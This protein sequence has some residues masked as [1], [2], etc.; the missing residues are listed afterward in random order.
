[1]R[2]E[3]TVKTK[4][5]RERI[6]DA[7]GEILH[8]EGA[9]KLTQPQVARAAGIRQS[10]LTYY[11]PRRADLLMAL[12]TRFLETASE[13]LGSLSAARGATKPRA[14]LATVHRLVTNPRQ[15]RSFLGLIVEADQDPELR[16]VLVK[17]IGKVNG[18]VAKYLGRPPNDPAVGL[19]LSA[20]RGAGL[21]SLLLDRSLT[22]KEGEAMGRRLGL[23]SPQSLQKTPRPPR[24]VPAKMKKHRRKP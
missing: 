20:L 17:H 11:F 10:H 23:I 1:M 19:L 21:E 18:L 2:R 3:L 15:M 5:L 7:A 24:S 22:A 4:G 6:V 16:A 8:R 9:R 14:V 12:T 13:G